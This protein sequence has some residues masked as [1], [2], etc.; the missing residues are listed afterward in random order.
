MTVVPF[1][2][3]KLKLLNNKKFHQKRVPISIGCWNVR[4]LLDRV[5]SGRPERRTALVTDEFKRLNLDIIA[6]SET[7]FSGE[8][9]ISEVSSG[10][11]IFWC[12]KPVGV[13]RDGGVG[14][15]I[16]TELLDRIEQP[17]GINDRVMKLRVPLSGG[18]FLS[19]V[20]V[21]APTLQASTADLNSFYDALSDS[22]RSI[23]KEEK[24]IVLGDFNSRVG[25]DHD[26]WSVLGPHGIGKMNSNGLRLLE[27]CTQFNL[28]ITNTFF[29]TKA[30]HKATWYHPR[31][32]HGHLIDF[33]LTRKSDLRDICNV[34]V[35]RSAECGTDH[36]LVRGK[37][38]LYIRK[39][40]RTSGV[41][42]PKRIDISKLHD[43]DLKKEFNQKL[44]N[45]NLTESWNSFKTQVYDTGAEVL[46]YVSKKHSDWFD[47]NNQEIQQLLETKRD[48]HRQ[49]LR[50]SASDK[51]STARFKATRS[52]VQRELRKIKNDWWHNLSSEIQEAYDSQNSKTFYSLLNQAFGPKSSNVSPLKSLDGNSVIK[53]ST[54]IMN[55]WKEHFGKLFFNPSVVDEQV[56]NSLPQETIINILDADP[57]IQEVSDALSQ[58][59]KGK[60]PGLDG[61]TVELLLAGGD[62]V[63]RAIHHFIMKSW[64]GQPIPQDWIDGVLV[65]LFKGKGTKSVCDN[66][67]G[68]TLLEAVGKVLARLLLN[69]LQEQICNNVFP[70]A[71]CGF[72]A[73][74][75]TTDMIFSVRQLQEKCIEQNVALFQVFVDLTK[76]F[77]TVNR[78]AMWT[79]LRKLGC[80]PNF[81]RMITELHRDMKG[82]VTVNGLLS[83]EIPIENGVKQGDIQAPTL[84]SLYFAALLLHAF[85][86]CET[87][88]FLRFR[89]TG[90]VFDLRR[91]KA[92]T[93][94]FT[95]LIRELLYAD[96]ADFVAHSEKDMQEIMDRFSSACTAFG[97]TISI[98]KTKVMFTPPP[99]TAYVEPSIYVNNERLEVVDTF[100]YL[101][102]TMA[103]DGNLDAEI[104]HR[105]AKASTAYGRLE[106]RVWSDR[107]LKNETK[108]L[109]YLACVLTALL[110]AAEA[111]TV[112]KR[113]ILTLERFHQQCLRRI[114]QIKWD[115]FTP[116]T[117]VLELAGIGS[118]ESILVQM[119]LRWAGH[120]SRMDDTRIPKRLLFG[121]LVE[122]KRKQCGVKFRFKDNL[123][124]NLNHCNINTSEWEALASNRYEWRKSVKN[125]CKLFE[126]NRVK[127]AQLKRSVRKGN[128][129]DLPPSVQTWPCEHCD[130]VLLS[131]AGYIGHVKSHSTPKISLSDGTIPPCPDDL[132]CAIC[133]KVCKSKGGL[134]KH[135][136]T[137]HK[138]D[139]PQTG[140]INPNQCTEN[141][142]HLCRRPCKSKA[143]LKSHLR[144]HARQVTS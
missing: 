8:D 141:V 101:G 40:M 13:R 12:G 69:R 128:V 79:I 34:K 26:T 43:S 3:T 111:W 46:G 16:K 129:T 73:N 61:I 133:F 130:R 2:S 132:T 66:Y 84:F 65:T 47:D 143:G 98:K 55:R 107:D 136:S 103:R 29:R 89:T 82:R 33:I 80:P 88:V 54:G 21:Y 140:P 138:N 106:S 74:R 134:K 124:K 18:R 37:F 76:A 64:H 62:K 41:R 57:T 14:F 17:C 135:V 126:E 42:V 105:V 28:A 7:R 83:D 92:K 86:N 50:S 77:D 102:S 70:E 68:I 59:N 104:S 1:C 137:V 63:V 100:I 72:R 51:D 117:K 19:I 131:K 25:T 95:A 139:I 67:R 58:V 109:V 90:S 78:K 96:D 99:G 71:Q 110:Y 52:K 6:L 15:A 5:H 56:I 93:K 39:K 23:P 11:S 24:V 75:G 113:H 48:L 81:I 142:C 119:N 94:T 30:K 91:L 20:S 123:K 108:L 35:L 27:F 4:T 53:D 31:S 45:A 10:Y 116:D 97:L 112:L 144:S 118:I 121:E 120:L 115:S 44:E 87:G 36:K 38:K 9:Q 85:K 114:L 60:A 49:V 127:Y 22:I 122:G 125:G 32:G